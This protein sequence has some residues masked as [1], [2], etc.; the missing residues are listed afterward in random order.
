MALVDNHDAEIY[1]PKLIESFHRFVALSISN[2]RLRVAQFEKHLTK[3][4]E[5]K[6][7]AVNFAGECTKPTLGELLSTQRTQAGI[8]QHD[9]A[10]RLGLPVWQ[11]IA[12]ESDDLRGF[13]GGQV[14]VDRILAL[15]SKKL[16]ISQEVENL[17]AE[18][19][20]GHK[21][22]PSLAM[23]NSQIPSLLRRIESVG[24]ESLR[25]LESIGSPSSP[26]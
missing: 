24:G 26:R 17:R 22:R 23:S 11:V 19:P 10:R 12:I 6:M 3:D 7:S 4:E 15:Y 1:L 16:G 21:T 8:N 9:M 18:L 20:Y 25:K 13:R 2:G 14:I 5:K